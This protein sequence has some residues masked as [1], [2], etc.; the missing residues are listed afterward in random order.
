[1]TQ[2]KFTPG[3]I[4]TVGSRNVKAYE[5]DKLSIRA[6][7]SYVSETEL[8]RIAQKLREKGDWSGLNYNE[9]MIMDCALEVIRLW[10][11]KFETEFIPAI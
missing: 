4:A 3:A 9:R 10:D 2:E 8:K 7:L 5:Y 11:A 6:A 1:M